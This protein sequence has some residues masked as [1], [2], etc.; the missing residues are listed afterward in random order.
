MLSIIA[1]PNKALPAT[2]DV[3]KAVFPSPFPSEYLLT[4]V[5]LLPTDSQ[6]QGSAGRSAGTNCVLKLSES[7]VGTSS[8]A[9]YLEAI[10]VNSFVEFSS[11]LSSP[12]H[13]GGG[14]EEEAEEV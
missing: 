6:P 5:Y 8:S 11:P 3:K 1:T 12:S 7:K 10:T 13:L 14:A 2:P 4:H 9:H